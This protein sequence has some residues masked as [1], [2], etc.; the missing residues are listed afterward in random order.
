MENNQQINTEQLNDTS[1]NS[2]DSLQ[3]NDYDYDLLQAALDGILLVR[4]KP[5][6]I[7]YIAEYLEIPENIAE[8]VVTLRKESYDNDTTSGLQLIVIESGIQLATKAKVSHYI[9]KMSGQRLV[10]LSLPALETLS[11]IAFKQPIT[12]A[13]IDAVRGV[14]SDGVVSTLLDKKLI[15]IS[16]E[17]KVIGHPR[18]YSTTQDFLYY[19]G[20]TSLKE[21][22]IPSVDVPFSLTPEGIKKEKSEENQQENKSFN[23]SQGLI[24]LDK[25]DITDNIN[26]VEGNKVIEPTDITGVD[27]SE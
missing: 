1:T 9:K 20:M 11:V 21:L 27:S 2:N 15:Y 5:V 19:F 8:N 26:H 22:P 14:N 18:L 16:G 12:K 13:E 23:Q 7:K 24:S 4:N 6:P 3:Q 10:T 17:K 25:E